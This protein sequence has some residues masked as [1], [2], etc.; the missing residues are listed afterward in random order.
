[1]NVPKEAK[2]RVLHVDDDPDDHDLFLRAIQAVCVS[3][4][5]EHVSEPD[6]VWK[7]LSGRPPPALPHVIITDGSFRT[8]DGPTFIAQVRERFPK[9]PVIALSGRDEQATVDRAYEA[10]VSAYLV[11]PVSLPELR[12]KLKAMTRFLELSSLPS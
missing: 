10:G 11:K 2:L 8:A 7:T 3:C 1:M 4:E 5:V 6:E 12:E 9:I